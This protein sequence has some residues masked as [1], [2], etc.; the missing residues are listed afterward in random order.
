M[1]QKL[2]LFDKTTR[3]ALILAVEDNFNEALTLMLP[4]KNGTLALTE[5]VDAIKTFLEGDELIASDSLKLGG[6]TSNMYLLSDLSNVDL[7]N[8][9]LHQA[10]YQTQYYFLHLLNQLNLIQYYILYPHRLY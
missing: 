4:S 9:F 7:D 5:D 8:L 6:K 3:K 2:T 10:L 1:K